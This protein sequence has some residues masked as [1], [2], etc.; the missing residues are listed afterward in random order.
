MPQE[1]LV[2]V[3]AT[4][5]EHQRHD[6]LTPEG[7]EKL[8]TAIGQHQPWLRST[9]P[10]SA[11]G[12]RRAADN[13]RYRQKGPVSKRQTLAELADVRAGT[14][15]LAELRKLLLA[16]CQRRRCWQDCSNAR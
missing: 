7:I 5:V 9:G 8:R 15:R 4:G 12:K 13:G 3:F 10:Q 1:P 6:R 2:D 14:K 11:A 16:A